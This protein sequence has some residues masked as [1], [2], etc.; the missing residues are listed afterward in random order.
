[1]SILTKVITTSSGL[2][3]ISEG[4]NSVVPIATDLHTA[5][6]EE[7]GKDTGKDLDVNSKG[8]GDMLSTATAPKAV[9]GGSKELPTATIPN[10]ASEAALSK[11]LPNLDVDSEG[12]NK[13][14]PLL[15]TAIAANTALEAAMGKFLHNLDTDS[16]G[17]NKLATSTASDADIGNVWT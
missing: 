10:I 2:E 9:E 5:S 6:D 17:N 15:P 7:M 3:V 12:G 14:L 13:E 8:G 16:E 4:G 11:F 1:M